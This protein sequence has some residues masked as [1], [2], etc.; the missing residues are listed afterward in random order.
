MWLAYGVAVAVVK[1][2]SCSSD[3]TPSLG[4]SMCYR[5][6]SKEKKKKKKGKKKIVTT[7]ASARVNDMQH[8]KC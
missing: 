5:C 4:T 7:R 2:G 3:W 1:S 8:V 6:R